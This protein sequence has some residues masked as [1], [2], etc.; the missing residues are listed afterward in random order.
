MNQGYTQIEA[1]GLVNQQLETFGALGS[2]PKQT[3]GMVIEALNAGDH[4]NVMIEWELPHLSARQ[5]Y[6]KYDVQRSMR[7]LHRKAG[8]GSTDGEKVTLEIRSSHDLTAT[9]SDARR[10]G[11]HSYQVDCDTF[12]SVLRKWETDKEKRPGPLGLTTLGLQHI[13]ITAGESKRVMAAI[14]ATRSR[15]AL[16]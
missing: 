16:D 9:S 8:Q 2:V 4:W 5:W 7:L 3:R 12:T 6:D 13:W 15:V 1:E 10:T 11:A 14:E